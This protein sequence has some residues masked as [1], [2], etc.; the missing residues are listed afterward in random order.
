MADLCSSR[1]NKIGNWKSFHRTLKVCE[2]HFRK[3]D[4]LHEAEFFDEKSMRLLKSEIFGMSHNDSNAA[5]S[6][7]TFM[8]QSLLS[9]YKDVAHILP[10]RSI[11]ADDFHSYIK[12]ILIGLAAIGF[13]VI[14]VATDNNAINKKAVTMFASPLE[15]RV[16]YDYPGSPG[17]YFYFSFDSVHIFTD[18][19]QILCKWWSIMNVKTLY[20]GEHKRDEFQTPLTPNTDTAQYKFLTNFINWLDKWEE[21]NCTTGGL[22]KQTHLAISHT[23]KAMLA[24]AEYCFKTLNFDYF[25]PGK[26]QTH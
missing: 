8:I 4:I 7:F 22:T 17:K 2:L 6:A 14:S 12:K 11:D 24:L 20:K 26:I 19:I 13:N 15:S 23:T 25:L 1:K 18:Y 3:E 9:P 5:S 10:V 16:R 21:M